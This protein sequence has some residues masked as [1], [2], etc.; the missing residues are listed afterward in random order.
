MTVG[1]Q[2][3][4]PTA[5]EKRVWKAVQCQDKIMV[6]TAGILGGYGI[7]AASSLSLEERALVIEDQSGAMG[8]F[9]YC[10]GAR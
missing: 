6:C 1:S 9:G 2:E 7:R 5:R 10:P 8:A 3:Q 4:N